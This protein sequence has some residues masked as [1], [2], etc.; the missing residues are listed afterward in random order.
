VLKGLKARV[1]LILVLLCFISLP[2]PLTTNASPIQDYTS[3]LAKLK[4]PIMAGDKTAAVMI[5]EELKGPHEVLVME[6]ERLYYRLVAV[7][8]FAVVTIVGFDGNYTRAVDAY[9]TS[10]AKQADFYASLATW[11]GGYTTDTQQL[12][13]ELSTT[14]NALADAWNY[15]NQTMI[16]A[17]GTPVPPIIAISL[18]GSVNAPVTGPIHVTAQ[19]I[20]YGD[21]AATNIKVTL[22]TDST[23]ELSSSSV[24]NLG[25]LPVGGTFTAQWTLRA[26][27]SAQPGYLS[28]YWVTAEADNLDPVE[29]DGSI[30]LTFGEEGKAEFTVHSP[31]LMMVTDNL[32]RRVGFNPDTTGI[33]NEIPNATYSGR[34]SSPQIIV[35]TDPCGLYWVDLLGTTDGN[36][37]LEVKTYQEEKVTSTQNNTGRA[38]KDKWTSI[39]SPVS[40]SKGTLLLTAGEVLPW[41]VVHEI[42]FSFENVVAPKDVTPGANDTRKLA[43]AFDCLT[44]RDATGAQLAYIDVGTEEAKQHLVGGWMDPQLNWEQVK[45]YAWAGGESKIATVRI[46]NATLAAFLELNL[47][48]FMQDNPMDIYYDGTHITTLTPIIGWAKYK[49][50]LATGE[51][52]V[53]KVKKSI[54]ITCNTSKETIKPSEEISI[55]VSLNPQITNTQIALNITNPS[56]HISPMNLSPNQQGTYTY[57][58]KS[59]D[60]GTWKVTASWNGDESYSN[61][62][63]KEVTWKVEEATQSGG[64]PNSGYEAALFGIIIALILLVSRH[65]S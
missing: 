26:S 62:T 30:L 10:L 17:M 48:P 59:Q 47:N 46:R 45:N 2:Y 23:L 31:V 61:A 15:M 57:S 9:T 28:A 6:L 39:A 20:N 24:A 58:F 12:L 41:A 64:I 35:V 22:S 16:I 21:E 32:G 51:I 52:I 60:I 54:L 43:T 33:L 8:P 11:L 25:S 49:V 38:Q 5:I 27:S 44:L 29:C 50:N 55:T 7:Y 14:S 65:K 19:V 63:S 36:Y 56:G 1:T 34:E 53:T 18:N 37:T 4:Q 3:T 42:T 40:V 13:S